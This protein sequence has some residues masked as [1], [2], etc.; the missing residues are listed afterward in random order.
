MVVARGAL[1]HSPIIIMYV[2]VSERVGKI[3]VATVSHD[4]TPYVTLI[5]LIWQRWQPSGHLVLVISQRDTV[6]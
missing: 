1:I 2:I 5:C 4:R 6:P 3:S